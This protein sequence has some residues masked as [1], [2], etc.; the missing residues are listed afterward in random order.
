MSPYLQH[1]RRHLVGGTDPLIIP[2]AFAWPTYFF[3]PLTKNAGIADVTS[4]SFALATDSTVPYNMTYTHTG[5][6][7]SFGVGEGDSIWYLLPFG[8]YTWY[9]HMNVKHGAGQGTI[10]MWVAGAY[11]IDTSRSAIGR[12]APAF[13]GSDWLQFGSVD[14]G[15]ASPDPA[16]WFG[17]SWIGNV[18]GTDTGP[19][20]FSI[21]PT[22]A[23][24]TKST[25]IDTT[26]DGG[27]NPNYNY[28]DGGVG[29]YWL[30]FNFTG[31]VEINEICMF[32]GTFF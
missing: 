21:D 8:P 2:P 1:A 29:Y 12:T 5:S 25:A 7:G 17:L 26:F 24:F 14:L 22:V 13:G 10:D 6:A 32:M 15:P 19:C 27:A 20:V 16:E 28:V 4:G 23:A 30:L 3:L 18:A 31:T 11:D 9:P